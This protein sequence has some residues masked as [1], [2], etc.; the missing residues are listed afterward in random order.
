MN[1]GNQWNSIHLQCGYTN[2]AGNIEKKK[3][4]TSLNVIAMSCGRKVWENQC[5]CK[6]KNHT[7]WMM[8]WHKRFLYQPQPYRNEHVAKQL[9][10]NTTSHPYTTKHNEPKPKL[11][12]KYL[13]SFRFDI[14]SQRWY[15][16]AASIYANI[17]Y[18][19][20]VYRQWITN[21]MRA[22]AKINSIFLFIKYWTVYAMVNGSQCLG[23]WFVS[24]VLLILRIVVVIC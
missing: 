1:F 15:P 9:H 4:N 22:T 7:H 2:N 6:M 12:A 10:N 19:C 3:L 16:H 21:Q 8:I 5:C 14:F 18:N 24:L 20:Y 23:F 13:R 11:N 17:L